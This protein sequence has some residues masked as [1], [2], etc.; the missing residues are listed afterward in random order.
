M[1]K[2]V[3]GQVLNDLWLKLVLSWQT[4][5]PL[6]GLISIGLV[7]EMSL[8]TECDLGQGQAHVVSN[9]LMHVEAHVLERLNDHRQ[10][11]EHKCHAVEANVA[12]S[13]HSCGL[14]INEIVVDGQTLHLFIFV[15]VGVEREI[16][17]LLR[18]GLRSDAVFAGQ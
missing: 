8:Q 9:V 14:L 4:S 10:V 15:T 6:E 16:G 3:G 13:V 12:K 2:Q 18:G 11:W 1:R 17:F 5:S 7:R